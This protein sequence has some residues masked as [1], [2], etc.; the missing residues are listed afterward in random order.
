MGLNYKKFR[1][2]GKWHKIVDLSTQTANNRIMKTNNVFKKIISGAWILGLAV[3][4]SCGPTR[5]TERGGEARETETTDETIESLDNRIRD[6]NQELAT[7]ERDIRATGRDVKGEV[8]ET[9]EQIEAKRK[10]LNS[11]IE[12]YNA[13]VQR[14]AE[15]EAAQIRGEID[16]Q[17]QNLE[18]EVNSFRDQF[19]RDTE[20]EEE[21][22]N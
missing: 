4:V 1:A 7:V 3:M 5:E 22:P 19:T 17:L 15:L 8:E 6:L 12:R 13:A 21:R 2:K 10:D 18:R 14:E 20:R 16:R 11:Q 9:W